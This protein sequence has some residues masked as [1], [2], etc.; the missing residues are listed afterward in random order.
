MP[1][2][3]NSMLI[4]RNFFVPQHSHMPQLAS[5]VVFDVGIV[6]LLLLFLPLAA[7]LIALALSATAALFPR[8]LREA[9]EILLVVAHPDDECDSSYSAELTVALFFAPC[10]LRTLWSG[11]AQASVLVLSAGNIQ[12]YH[13]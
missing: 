5:M 2:G 3:S 9:K 12:K 8:P 6:L 11:Q 1:A 4:D 13:T 7:Y 10:M